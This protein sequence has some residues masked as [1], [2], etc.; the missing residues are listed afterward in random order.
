MENLFNTK[1]DLQAEVYQTDKLDLINRL[2]LG[3]FLH[4]CMTPNH[5][6]T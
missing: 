5:S 1:A 3:Y 2:E 4:L 6:L